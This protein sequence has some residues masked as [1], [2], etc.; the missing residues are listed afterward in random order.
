MGYSLWGC[1]ELYTTE[2]LN[3]HAQ[4]SLYICT[5]ASVFI[6]LLM[7]IQVASMLTIVNNASMNIMVLVSF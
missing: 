4:N 1:K 3:M 7:D 6:P 2:Q 5:I